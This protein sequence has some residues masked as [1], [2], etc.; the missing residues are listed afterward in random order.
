LRGFY[1][2]NIGQWHRKERIAAIFLSVIELRNTEPLV[3]EFGDAVTVLDAATD[4]LCWLR[5]LLEL[6]LL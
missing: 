6:G 5:S 1:F 4:N 2:A 3:I